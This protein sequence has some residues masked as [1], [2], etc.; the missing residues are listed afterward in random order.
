MLWTSRMELIQF[1]ALFSIDSSNVLCYW[2]GQYKTGK[3]ERTY[4]IQ[5]GYIESRINAS[6][7]I[8]ES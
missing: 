6:F 2:N 5:S 1:Y 3:S 4:L 8:V 7:A